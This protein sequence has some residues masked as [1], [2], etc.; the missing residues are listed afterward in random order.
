MVG[1]V[2][3]R[4]L[5]EAGMPVKALVRETSD[6]GKVAKLTALGIQTVVGDL[7]NPASLQAACQGV[8]TVIDTVS[9]MPFSYSPGQND[10]QHVDVLG[11][12]ALVDAAKAAGAKHFIYT[13]FSGN[14]EADFPLCNAKREAEAY[15]QA[16]G[17]VYTVL[18]PGYFMESWLSP[19]VG[20]DAANAKAAVY[21]S[22]DQPISWIS[23]LDVAAYAV[24]SVS[25]PAARNA[26]LELG[27]PEGVSPHKVIKFLEAQG[28][29]AFEVSHVPAEA[30]KAQMEG[31]DDPM[32]KSFAGLM[33]GFAGGDPIDM[34]EIQKV[35]A[36]KPTSVWDF[37]KNILVQA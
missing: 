28:G 5:V 26:V 7:R 24:E 8:D 22:G 14:I 31:A 12:K 3:C 33:Y 34:R 29:K 1:S 18:R 15:L 21:G 16:S 6:A 19:M 23:F 37:A 10:V 20:F 30:L 32:Q 11:A 27:G 35:F 13:S 9:A 17:L 4:R 36:V 2:I 25:N